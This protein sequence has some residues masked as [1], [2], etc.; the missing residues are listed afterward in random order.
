[1]Y[2]LALEDLLRMLFRYGKVTS[3]EVSLASPLA[4]RK[5][6]E[7]VH[8]MIEANALE[9]AD[10]HY[11]V[12]DPLA[13]LAVLR[14]LGID[15]TP[16]I[17]YVDWRDFENYVAST[18]EAL[19]FETHLDVKST[20]I[21]RFQIDVL[22]LDTVSRIGL[23]VECKHWSRSRLRAL[24]EEAERLVKRARRF[25]DSCEWI[26]IHIPSIRRV[27]IFVPM[28]VAIRSVSPPIVMGIPIVE[29]FKLRDFVEN[30]E[31][32]IEEL[33]LLTLSNRCF[34]G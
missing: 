11:V 27:R 15:P 10:D 32:Y 8:A 26:A 17:D 20:S 34:C 9:A 19:G 24:Q 1:M 25:V 18:L 22:G 5:F 14:R 12:R 13:A 3:H 29:V 31:S 23:V 7:I 6:E 4:R 30:L 2:G 21:K 28:I 16:Y 33:G